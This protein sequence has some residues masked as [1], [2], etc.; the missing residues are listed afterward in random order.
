ME[1]ALIQQ[2]LLVCRV[3]ESADLLFLAPGGKGF[4]LG[5]KRQQRFEVV[6]LGIGT[7]SL[8]LGHRSPGDTKLPGQ[9]SLGQA[10]GGAQR[11][12]QLTEGIISLT[13]GGAFH[14]RSPSA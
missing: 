1:P 7:A 6:G 14:E 2:H 11:L 13:V 12:H 8:P 3:P 5:G 9:A 10:D 4:L